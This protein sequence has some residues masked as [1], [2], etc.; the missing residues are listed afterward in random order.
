[1]LVGGG[2]NGPT[3]F[4]ALQADFFTRFMKCLRTTAAVARHDDLLRKA[5]IIGQT[6]WYLREATRVGAFT[7]IHGKPSVS[8]R[9]RLVIG[10][11]VTVL[12]RVVP[13]ELLVFDNA[14]LE[15]GDGTFIN[16]GSSISAT[17]SV[18]V[19][20]NCLLGMYTIILDNDFHGVTDRLA[21][22][23]PRP[24]VLQD[25]VW[26]GHRT[27]VLPGVTVG[28]DSIVGSGSVVT[29]DIPSRSVAV[30]NPARVIRTL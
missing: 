27:L 13:V 1:M 15:I 19:G 30:G 21:R 2:R 18:S 8:N 23:A 11:H 24:V 10:E 7:R 25:N 4:S 16:Y 20:R 29:R 6:R 28:R 5:I 3:L 14:S 22:P 26:L 12:S 17:G 9:G